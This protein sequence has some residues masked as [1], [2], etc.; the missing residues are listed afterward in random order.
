[1]FGALYLR[2][3]RV[4]LRLAIVMQPIH[5]YFYLS[6]L[7]DCFVHSFSLS[8]FKG[9]NSRIRKQVMSIHNETGALP[10]PVVVIVVLILL[11]LETKNSSH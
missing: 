11:S 8:E 2:A 6:L 1:M 4:K 3:L 5:S 10:H 9:V 7:L